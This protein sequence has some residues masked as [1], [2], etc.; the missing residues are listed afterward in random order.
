M[1]KVIKVIL[2][3]ERLH[4]NFYIPCSEMVSVVSSSQKI[5]CKAP[6]FWS[7]LFRACL[8]HEMAKW[9]NDEMAKWRNGT[10]DKSHSHKV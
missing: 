8:K 7:E 6:S 5:F 10:K 9:R 3:Q 4:R 2:I 1:I